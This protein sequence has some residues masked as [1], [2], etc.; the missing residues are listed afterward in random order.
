M[1]SVLNRHKQRVNLR[2]DAELWEWVSRYARQNSTTA[3]HIVTQL[4][5]DLKQSEDL[6]GEVRQL[7]ERVVKDV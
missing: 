1:C 6:L 7:K 5:R 3:T 4:L 2:L